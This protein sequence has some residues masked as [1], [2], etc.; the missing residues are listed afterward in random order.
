MPKMK[1]NRMARKKLSVNRNGKVKRAHAFH[2]HNTGK[3]SAKSKRKLSKMGLVDKTNVQAIR[4]LLP[5]A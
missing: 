3:K 1:T 5:Y 4:R 2:S